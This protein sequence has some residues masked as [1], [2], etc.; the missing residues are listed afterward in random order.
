MYAR[1]YTYISHMQSIR[2]PG[3][4]DTRSILTR[5]TA[6]MMVSPLCHVAI[7]ASEPSRQPFSDTTKKRKGRKGTRE[8][9]RIS[10]NISIFC[11]SHDVSS[12]SFTKVY[13]SLPFSFFLSFNCKSLCAKRDL[14]SR[15]AVHSRRYRR[16]RFNKFI[17]WVRL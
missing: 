11:F 3:I 6:P 7:A 2:S 15:H 1:I 16:R 12:L 5:Y 4:H 14:W 17:R 8:D 9:N 10:H 13:I